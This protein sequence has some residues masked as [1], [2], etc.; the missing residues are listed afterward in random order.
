[1]KDVVVMTE[2]INSL[3]GYRPRDYP[4]LHIPVAAEPLAQG[5][6]LLLQRTFKACPV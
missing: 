4:L 6:L 2:K 3:P 1:M 5:R